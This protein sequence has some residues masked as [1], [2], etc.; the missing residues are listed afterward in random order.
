ME[1]AL[2][3]HTDLAVLQ[4]YGI[5]ALS[6]RIKKYFKNRSYGDDVSKI[7]FV[8][9][10]L[11]TTSLS[12][13]FISHKADYIDIKIINENLA[14]HEEISKCIT[15]VIKPDYKLLKIS[16]TLSVQAIIAKA[17]IKSSKQLISPKRIKDF[18]STAFW[19]DLKS[20]LKESDY[21]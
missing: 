4:S 9:I 19:I 20:F 16:D 6:N 21:M 11:D 14:N 1:V 15:W 13:I 7:T 3:L 17:I 12:Q 5:M 10:A 8:I 18:N 2:S